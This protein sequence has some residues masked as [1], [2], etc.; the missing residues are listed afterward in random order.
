VGEAVRAA[1]YTLAVN[2]TDTEAAGDLLESLPL[3]KV[4]WSRL[5]AAFAVFL[6]KLGE[7]ENPEEA[8]LW[9]R[10]LVRTTALD[11]F[12]VTRRAVGSK[13]RRAVMA[14]ESKL[15]MGLSK[16]GLKKEEAA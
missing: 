6:T 9:W 16:I 4:Y 8:Y 7:S 13:G 3:L 5:E 15:Y 11:A 10:N 14:G 12:E 2:L 1:G